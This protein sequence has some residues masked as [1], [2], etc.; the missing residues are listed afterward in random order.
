MLQYVMNG[1]VRGS[2]RHN[3]TYGHLRDF[4]TGLL[5]WVSALQ[6]CSEVFW[7]ELGQGRLNGPVYT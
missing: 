4:P 5:R 1:D 2:G 3:A 7:C 6:R